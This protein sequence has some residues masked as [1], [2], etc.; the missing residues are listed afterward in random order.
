MEGDNHKIKEVVPFRI[1]E[2]VPVKHQAVNNGAAV[3]L[4]AN[5]TKNQTS[6]NGKGLKSTLDNLE[7][8]SAL[9]NRHARLNLWVHGCRQVTHLNCDKITRNK[10]HLVHGKGLGG[11]SY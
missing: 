1:K 8:V 7:S 5:R 3:K 6:I 11:T 4:G 9:K 10:C 2:A